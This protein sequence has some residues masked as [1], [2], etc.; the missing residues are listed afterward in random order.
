M[1]WVMSQKQKLFVALGLAISAFFLWRAFNGLNPA[2]VW[3]YI[4][5]AEVGWLLVGV[6]VFYASMVAIAWRWQ[7]L[8]NSIT[9]IPLLYL[10]ELVAIGYMGNNVYPFRS[11]EILRIVLLHRSHKVPLARTTVTILVERV[12]DGLVMLTFILVPLLVIEIASPELRM[13]VSVAAPIFLVALAVFFVLAAKPDLLRGLVHQVE[14]VLPEKFRALI[15]GLSED[16]ILGLEGLRSPKDLSGTIFASFLTWVINAA[17]YWVVG[18]AFGLNVSFPVML[19]VCG[20]VNL[21]GLIPASPGQ[22]GIF[23]FFT[24]TTLVAVLGEAARQQV[25]AYALVVHLVIWLP[26]TLLG[27]FCLVRRGLGL[28][29]VTRARELEVAQQ[30]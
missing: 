17:V 19:V 18:F 12:F 15:T 26:P 3:S 14:K 1:E 10:S 24:V 6:L 20:V 27:F 7:F 11:G 29:A 23:E 25:T 22:I 4:Q 21:A 9:R 16:I 2:A 13:A 28:S 8:L 30:Q 5:Q